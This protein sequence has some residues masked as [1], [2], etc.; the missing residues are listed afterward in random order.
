MNRSAISRAVGALWAAA[1]V[2]GGA[3]CNCAPGA[4][5]GLDEA[6]QAAAVATFAFARPVA[7][8]VSMGDG[9]LLAA[10]EDRDLAA[11]D[12]SNPLAPAAASEVP[13]AG[14][15]VAIDVDEEREL[16]FVVDTTGTVSVVAVRSAQGASSLVSVKLPDLG[17][18]A[19]AIAR[20]GA[21][22]FVLGQGGL[23]S[24]RV[25]FV[26][27]DPTGIQAEPTTP[28]AAPG[29]ALAAGGGQLY[30]AAA[31][32]IHAWEV[33]GQ[34][35]PVA[36]P[37]AAIE[38]EVRGLLGR[39]SRALV[40]AKDVG[41]V[42]LDFG[43]PGG[44][45]AVVTRIP[46]LNDV[47]AARL[48]G[49]TLA[50]ALERGSFHTIDL[51][52]FTRPR[53][54]STNKGGLPALLALHSGNLV[55]GTRTQVQLAAIPPAIAA[56]VPELQRRAFP[57]GGVIPV[58][59]T[60][61]IDAASATSATVTLSCN[62]APIAGAVVVGLGRLSLSF[63]PS[64]PLPLGVG[65]TLDL[66]GVRDPFGTPVTA[67]ARPP[68]LELTTATTARAPV[69][70]AGSAFAHSADG[71]FTDWAPG[72]TGYEWSDV[73]P[74]RGM[75]SYFYA[76][77]D[78]TN[79]WLLNDWFFNDEKIDP[80]CY[81][82][83]GA[84]TGGGAERWD[85]R[86][87][88]DKRVEVRKNGALLDT[89]ASGVEGGYTFGPS[90]NV[91]VRHTI[92]E[93]KIP[94]RAGAWGLQLHDPGPTFHCSRRVG[95]PAPVAGGLGQDAGGARASTSDYALI[96]PPAPPASSAPEDGARGVALAPTL[97]WSSSSGPEQFVGYLVQLGKGEDFTAPLWQRR[98]STTSLKLP[99][100]LLVRGTTYAWRVVAWNSAGSAASK[101]SL[102]TT[103]D[104]GPPDGGADAGADAGADGGADAGLDAGTDGGSSCGV[105]TCTGTDG[106][107]T[108]GCYQTYGGTD[109]SVYCGEGSC[110]CAPIRDGGTGD[111]GRVRF[112]DETA[113][114]S[115]AYL[116][117]L[118]FE[119][120]GCP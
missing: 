43:A 48:F 84:W 116:R 45:P 20:V 83:F 41:L 82:Q 19:K 103:Q 32:E 61:R 53:A 74:A 29:D 9:V 3:A 58:S 57:V 90:P 27:D 7:F 5:L 119:R 110:T 77:F 72:A 66:S 38:G 120:C 16:A 12:M 36:G 26:D 69:A 25:T 109:Y 76:D 70:N 22:V 96:A 60:K 21:R 30:V 37:S 93:L 112:N 33:P 114:S 52:D 49:R 79:L 51:S 11:F 17:A 55:F 47:T 2:A 40:L 117:T 63:R 18:S 100:A 44:P 104:L 39:G 50:V 107:F 89:A 118:Y 67:G 80:D 46:E 64:D 87:Y 24:A 10:Y 35:A 6:P 28:L 14:R 1:A 98:T 81:N 42:V 23:H 31:G 85:I 34:G 102:F 54:L 111:G 78:G 13:M 106:G 113:C 65:C 4:G 94:A 86:A 68:R 115:A 8:T 99:R 92:Y 62:G 108:C 97:Q 59:F 91:D 95:D 73:R 105:P 88:G 101:T 56:T 71:A 15:A 75:Y